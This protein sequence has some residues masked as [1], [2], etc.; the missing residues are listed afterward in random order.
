VFTAAAEHYDRFM[1]RYAHPLVAQ[2]ADVAGVAAGMRVLD[3][4]CGPGE[5]AV[6]LARRVGGEHVAAIDPAT[7]FV[8]ACRDRVPEADVREGVAED[9]P[10]D[11]ATFDAALSSLVV[12]FMSD[13]QAGVG[14]MARV[15]RPGGT[16]AACMWDIAG[17]GMAMLTTFWQAARDVDPSVAGERRRAGTADGDLRELLTRTGLRDVRDGVLEVEVAYTDFD[18]L[19]EPFTHGVG[20]AGEH[21]ASLAPPDAGRVRDGMRARVGGD[22]PFTLPARAWYAVGV[23]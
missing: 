20:P 3:V 22:G 15:T 11:D 23:R 9:L 4:G 10:W 21:L 1:G 18:D 2:L 13:A 8:A 16:I 12:A 14:E 5:L 17:D 7:Q 6:E 19:W